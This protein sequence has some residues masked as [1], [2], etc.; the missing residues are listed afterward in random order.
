MATENTLKDVKN[1]MTQQQNK[2]KGTKVK[3]TKTKVPRCSL[4]DCNKKL[5][6][7]DMP[8]KCKFIYCSKH[9][10]QHQHN[11]ILKPTVNKDILSNIGGGV[12]KKITS[13]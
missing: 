1:M 4:E 13:I 2:K 8:C 6:L 12:F 11:C 3:K 10:L 7:S 5:K 9:R